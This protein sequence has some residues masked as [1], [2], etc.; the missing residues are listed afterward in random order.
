MELY[1]FNLPIIFFPQNRI[2]EAL[3]G[4]GLAHPRRS[5][6]NNVLFSFQQHDQRVVLGFVHIY[7]VNE[8]IFAI[9]GRLF[10]SGQRIRVS[11]LVHYDVIFPLRKLEQASLRI[12][13]VLRF[14]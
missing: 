3:C 5:L 14:L 2:G 4:K 10:V 1:K 13:K 8:I 6:Q 11:D 7:L 9:Y 12:D